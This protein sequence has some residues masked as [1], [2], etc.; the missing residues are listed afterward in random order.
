MKTAFN[1]LYSQKSYKPEDLMQVAEF[2]EV[3]EATADV[4]NSAIP[5]EVPKEMRDYLEKDVFIFS[6]L[7]T[8]SQL[9]EARSFLKDSKGNITPYHLFEQKVLKLNEKYNR[10][11]LEAEYEFAVHSAQSAANWANLQENTER[12]WLEYRTAGDERVRASHASLNGICLPKN[13]AF[14]TEYYPPNGWRCRCV[15]VEVL[16]RE[17][18]ISDPQKAKELGDKATT[19]ISA[20]GKNKLAMFRFNPGA[21][22]KVF[23]PNNTY[24]KVVGA[25]EVKKAI[26]KVSKKKEDTSKYDDG[27]FSLFSE[28]ENEVKEKWYYNKAI[29]INKKIRPAEA[30]S[31]N[32]YTGSFYRKINPYLRGGRI[33][34]NTDFD[35]CI[36]VI[37]SGLDKL[38]TY[39]GMV[40]RGADL[41][42]EAINDYKKALETGKTIIEKYYFSTSSE[43]EK[44]F[45]KNTKYRVLSKRG[46]MIEEISQFSSEKEVLFKEGSKFKVKNI[47]EEKGITFIDMEE[48]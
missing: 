18:T 7:K 23:P 25:N 20:N 31:M 41:S 34:P 22:K 37:N 27:V 8:H 14:W 46:K 4:F 42:P 44:S 43:E 16:A 11:Y 48:V 15:A 12:Y 10:Y 28:T 40:F 3:V 33:P 13:D 36:K 26:T 47:K 5:H 6:G 29:E 39:K 1:K 21:E 32:E 35:K 38:K 24:T 45:T 17:K 19:Q 2:R 30:L 9:T